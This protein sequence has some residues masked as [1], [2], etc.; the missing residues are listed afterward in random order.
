MKSL[1]TK[2][3]SLMDPVEV[4]KLLLNGSITKFPKNF[5]G[6][7]DSKNLEICAKI[8]RYLIKE[9]LRWNDEELCENLSKKIF[10]TYKLRGMLQNIFHNSPYEAIN[11][12]FPNH[13]KP[14]QLNC[15]PKGYWTL[16][17]G[18]EATIWLLEE[19]L[20]WNKKQICAQISKKTF[21]NN[22]FGGMLQIVFHDSPYEAITQSYPNQFVKTT[23][24]LQLIQS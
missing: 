1:T 12:A 19:K 10:Y 2:K 11:N 6:K 17:T 15:I 4:Y 7:S 3:L 13:F 22:R 8:T 18:S 23:R 16:E 5:F 20:K 24:K 14:F 21:Y 9:H